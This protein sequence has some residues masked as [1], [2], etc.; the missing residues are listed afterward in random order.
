MWAEMLRRE[1]IQVVIKSDNPLIGYGRAWT[2]LD[3]S[4][5]VRASHAARA[6]DILAPLRKIHRSTLTPRDSPAAS[7]GEGDDDEPSQAKNAPVQ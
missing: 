1:G 4:L 3:F 2:T 6:R 5:H 7:G